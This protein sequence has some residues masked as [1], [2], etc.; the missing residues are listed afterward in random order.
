MKYE[1]QTERQCAVCNELFTMRWQNAKYCS[2]KCQKIANDEKWGRNPGKG[3]A[4]GTVGAIS[5]MAVSVDLMEKGF[6]VFRA[7]SA[8]CFC[9]LIAIRKDE[10]LKVEVRTGYKGIKDNISFSMGPK[11]YGRQDIFGVYLRKLKEIHYFDTEKN[12]IIIV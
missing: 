7:L 10:T 2:S 3:I 1:R 4:T 8:A 11:D 12:E 6:A 5:E 9:D